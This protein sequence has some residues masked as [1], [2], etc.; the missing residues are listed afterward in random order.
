MR[1]LPAE[2]QDEAAELL[3]VPWGRVVGHPV[4]RDEGCD[5]LVVE[6]RGTLRRTTRLLAHH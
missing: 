2:R 5:V 3:E 4:E 1:K 6:G